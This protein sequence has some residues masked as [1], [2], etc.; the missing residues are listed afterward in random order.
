MKKQDSRR[1]GIVDDLS[2]DNIQDMGRNPELAHI[3]PLTYTEMM[4]EKPIPLENILFPWFPVQGIAFIYAATGVGK[5]MFT[6]NIAYAIASGGQFL[7]YSVPKPRKILYVDGEMAYSQ[8][9]DRFTQIVRQ[10]GELYYP[11]NWNLLTPD[12]AH[13]FKLPK[14]CD[15]KGQEFYNKLIDELGIEVL[16]LDNL[17]VLSTIDESSS[18]EWKPIQ[19]WLIF[20]RGKGIGVIVVHHAGKDKK[21]YRGTSRMLDCIDTA[22]S[23][24]DLSESQL[25]TEAVLNKKFKIDY[26]KARTFGGKD[27]LQFEVTLAPT[28]WSHQSMEITTMDR[29]IEM[30]KLN[31]SHKEISLELGFTRSYISRLVRKGIK[32][33]LIRNEV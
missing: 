20:L 18:E 19:D 12:K 28:G 22:I 3:K 5:T 2:E 9:H 11:D 23:L 21:G 16:F 6:L 14:I 8:M 29:I 13:P 31:M 33:G 17:S 1:P 24:Q 10:Q 26:Q 27:A 4:V 30:L 7:K 32:E 25:E 15:P